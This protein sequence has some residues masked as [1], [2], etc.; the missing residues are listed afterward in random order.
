MEPVSGTIASVRTLAVAGEPEAY[1]GTLRSMRIE[2][3]AKPRL[4]G[5]AVAGAKTAIKLSSD[6]SGAR[7]A[8]RV[9]EVLGKRIERFGLSLHLGRRARLD[10]VRSVSSRDNSQWEGAAA[11]SNFWGSR[12]TAATDVGQVWTLRHERVVPQDARP[13][14]P[15]AIPSNGTTNGVGN[16]RHLPLEVQHGALKSI[17]VART[18]QL[19]RSPNGNHRRL[20][21]SGSR[22]ATAL[23]QMAALLQ[24]S[25]C[26]SRGSGSNMRLSERVALPAAR[27]TVVRI[28][29]SVATRHI[30]GGAAW[31]KSPCP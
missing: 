6:S 7:D 25:A 12:C 3:E 18:L 28:W 1:I 22:H 10:C 27:R 11:R 9:A 19:L 17:V 30:S 23:A 20:G 13:Q 2:R 14:W 4:G 26:V 21:P 29:R 16:H 8:Q 5:D 24:T 31:W 15:E